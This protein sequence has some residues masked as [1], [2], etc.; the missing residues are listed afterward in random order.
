M[1]NTRNV[2]PPISAAE[3]MSFK[4]KVLRAFVSLYTSAPLQGKSLSLGL[5]G[6]FLLAA[7]A[8]FAGLPGVVPDDAK[9]IWIVGI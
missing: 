8:G 6:L 9:D 4:L 2:T 1:D 5:F 3:N 7:A